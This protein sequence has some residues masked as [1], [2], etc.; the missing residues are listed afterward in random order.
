[1]QVSDESK[2]RLARINTTNPEAYQPYLKGR[3]RLRVA[4]EGLRQNSDG[5]VHPK[6]ELAFDNL[7]SDPRF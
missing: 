5:L 3:Y 4:G 6:E 7:R 2:E 1:L